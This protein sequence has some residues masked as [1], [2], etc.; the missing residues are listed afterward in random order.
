MG[1][2]SIAEKL[3]QRHEHKDNGD[4]AWLVV[5][6]FTKTKPPTKFWDNL[7][8]L[9]ILTGEGSLVQYSVFL[10]HDMRGALAAADLVKHY[11]G[12]VML[13]KGELFP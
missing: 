13:F 12:D 11:K 2:K 1:R 10:T 3:F 5:Y 9:Q 8:R 4:S 7:K 6:D